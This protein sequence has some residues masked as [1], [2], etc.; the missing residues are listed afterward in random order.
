M[1]SRIQTIHH[2]KK[3]IEKVS[4]RYKWHY[5]GDVGQFQ[6]SNKFCGWRINQKENFVEKKWITDEIK[7]ASKVKSNFKILSLQQQSQTVP[8]NLKNHYLAIK[9][10]IKNLCNKALNCWLNK[11]AKEAEQEYEKNLKHGR[12]DSLSKSLKQLGRSHK[13]NTQ[14]LL[15]KDGGTKITSRTEKLKRWCEHFENT[16]NI[17]S[18]LDESSFKDLDLYSLHLNDDLSVPLSVSKIEIAIKQSRRGSATGIGEIST[19][20]LLHGSTE[21]LPFFV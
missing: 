5:W 3:I 6:N 17:K 18:T 13:K 2:S 12:G 10:E 16:K 21:V 14:Y 15:S 19:E 9:K 1:I 8:E 7:S 11:R 4:L 20:L